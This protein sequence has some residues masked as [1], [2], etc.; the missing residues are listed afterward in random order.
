MSNGS[1]RLAP[2]QHAS[3][4]PASATDDAAPFPATRG[5][6]RSKLALAIA[7]VFVAV[8]A[9]GAAGGLVIWSRIPGDLKG[10][11]AQTLDDSAGLVLVFAA[12]MLIALAML[13]GAAFRAYVEGMVRLAEGARVILDANPA[14][15][16]PDEGP[17][18]AMQ[19]ARLINGLAD[20][21]QSALREIESR[22]REANAK[23][24]EEK[25]R[26]AALMSELTDGV[27]VCNPEGLILLYNEA[28]R[29]LFDRPDGATAPTSGIVGL[30]R[31]VFG[32]IDR[33]LIAHALDIVR[34]RLHHGEARPVSQFVATLGG[35]RLIR[36][37]M[38]P[39][40]GAPDAGPASA[41]TGFVLTLDDVTGAV[42]GGEARDRLV[43]S[44]TQDTRA[45]L[46]SIRAAV[47]TIIEYG[48]MEP[49]R[50]EQFTA[51]IRDEAVRLTERLDAMLGRETA[52]PLAPWPLEEMKG[53]D[54]L[55][56]VQRSVARLPGV[57]ASAEPGSSRQWL[58]VDSF[59]VVQSFT[60]LAARLRRESGIDAFA[61]RLSP[62]GRFTGLEL[63][64][65]SPQ[66]DPT[67]VSAWET[68]PFEVANGRGQLSLREVAQRH[69]GEQWCRAD[70]QAGTVT[71]CL[72]LPVA[73]DAPTERAAAPA[74]ARPV[75]YD[76]E[77]FDRPGRTSAFEA[78]P[79]TE[80]VYTV[81]D[82]ETTGLDPSA[83][84]E[85]ISLS[86]V[87]IVNGRLLRQESFDQ[88]VD[89]RRSLS[90]ESIRIHGIT[91]AMLKGQPT[92]A[93]VLPRFARFAEDT[94]LVGHNV[95]FDM[96]FLQMK[97]RESGQRFIQPVLDTLLL[98]AVVQ[99]NLREHEL[100]ANAQRLGIAIIGRHTSLGDAILTGEIFIKLI[101]LLA[102]QG[103]VTL[104]E[105][106]AAS[107]RTFLARVQ[108]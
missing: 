26:L 44:L 14:H 13:I 15:R 19:L 91:P 74:P 16:L 86:A 41:I 8:V 48:A 104:G 20:R 85:I 32:I 37:Q 69:G 39:V 47:E 55:L 97:E 3:A 72:Q 33:D 36:V 49:Q 76:F 38:A 77:L 53:D 58:Q 35:S 21:H 84:D 54:L 83:G 25:H 51:I 50:R 67:A 59:A 45:G 101:P 106:L 63:T 1:V 88:L 24:E 42:H 78:R 34:E 68:E 57:T 10:A 82:T 96:R 71:Y 70:R 9:I 80:L 89:P 4:V 11:L 23:L 18:E 6:L 52:G 98:S 28:A 60:A 12:F 87:R 17:D 105:A 65:R 27:L 75:F 5:K 30:G 107:Q 81:F 103:I 108:Y 102:A 94:V 90:S 66:T 2:K 7:I 95:A 56:T 64:W 99:P 92:I 61:L 100:E 73:A 43:Q 62:G 79:L 31:S 40:L 93:D 46:A 29:A 22:V